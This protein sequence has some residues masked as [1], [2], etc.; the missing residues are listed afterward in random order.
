MSSIRVRLWFFARKTKFEYKNAHIIDVFIS[1]QVLSVSMGTWCTNACNKLKHSTSFNR[2]MTFLYIFPKNSLPRQK[3]TRRKRGTRDHS[4]LVK[5]YVISK[6]DFFW[7]C[8]YFEVYISK[9][10]YFYLIIFGIK[11][12][13]LKT[14]F[15]TKFDLLRF[16]SL[17][18]WFFCRGD[19][20]RFLLFGI[21]F[22]MFGKRSP[23][24]NTH[25]YIHL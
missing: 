20:L 19:S 23:K 9:Y 6:D 22:S 21:S 4:V 7:V 11:L 18:S 15:I 3:K 5:N 16:R 12:S 17:C 2:K 10:M 1:K 24:R 8:F 13:A 25:W 14:N